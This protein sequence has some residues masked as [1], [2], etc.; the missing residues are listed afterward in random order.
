MPNFKKIFLDATPVIYF[1]QQDENF[2]EQAK[3]I[4]KFIK[5]KNFKVISSDVTTAE[6]CVYAYRQK[7]FDWLN[8]FDNL[9][10]FLDV[11][12][13]HTTEEIAR[14]TSK[15][16]AEYKSFETPDAFQLATAVI[17]GC[18]IFL[19]NDK[20][21]RKF[22]EIEIITVEDFNF[23]EQNEFERLSETSN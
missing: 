14:K 2:F 19:T 13:L 8:A 12:T 17:S 10:K 7:N 16:R 22:S 4:F 9:M 20:R 3:K 5:E 1:I 23:G 21:L 11:K 15:I 6:A 18:D